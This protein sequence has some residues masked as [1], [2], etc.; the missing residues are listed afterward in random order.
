MSILMVGFFDREG[1]TSCLETVTSPRISAS[2]G[3][4]LWFLSRSTAAT[5]Q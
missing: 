3:Q 1:M 5:A 4:S 2:T